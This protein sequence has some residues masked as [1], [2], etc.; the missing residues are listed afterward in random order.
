MEYGHFLFTFH[1]L[2]SQVEC[3]VLPQYTASQT[4]RGTD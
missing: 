1:T 3:I 2:V 4:D